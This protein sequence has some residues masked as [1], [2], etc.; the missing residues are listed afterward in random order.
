MKVFLDGNFNIKS[1]T[2]DVGE[3]IVRGSNS[4]DK[5]YVYVPTSVISDY[6]TISPLYA[7]KR[8]DGRELGKYATLTNHASDGDA[9]DN[10]YGWYGFFDKRDICV[11]GPLEITISF[12]LVKN[13]IASEKSVCKVTVDIKDGVM[14]GDDVLILDN[15]DWLSLKASIEALVTNLANKAD[16]TN[17][18]QTITGDKFYGSY[19]DIIEIV[20]NTVEALSAVI[21]NL[22]VQENITAGNINAT[23]INGTTIKQ[24]NNAVLDVR[25]I[26]DSFISESTT[27]ALSAKKGKEL[28]Y[29]VDTK[30]ARA[31]VVNNLT[32]TSINKPLSAKQGKILKDE[33][34]YIYTLLDSDDTSLDELQEIVTYIKNNKSLID[35]ITTSKVSVSDIV[36]NLNSNDT[37]K[38]LSAKQGHILK[39]LINNLQTAI[40]NTYT[41]S[42]TDDLLDDKADKSTTYTKDDVDDKLALK[43][44]ITIPTITIAGVNYTNLEQAIGALNEYA[45]T[46]EQVIGSISGTDTSI[47]TKLTQLETNLSNL[48]TAW[49]TFISGT[50]AD[51]II[52]T[53]SEIQDK[54]SDIDDEIEAIFKIKN[55]KSID[56]G[57]LTWSSSVFG[58][59]GYYTT[60]ALPDYDES[61]ITITSIPTIYTKKFPLVVSVTDLQAGDDNIE[62]ITL[63]KAGAIAV[64]TTNYSSASEFKAALDGVMLYYSTEIKEVEKTANKSLYHLGAFDTISGNTITRQTYYTT[65]TKADNWVLNSNGTIYYNTKSSGFIV[66]PSG[67]N[68]KGVAYCD[69]LELVKYDD[70]YSQSKTSGIA[71]SANGN[72]A[73]SVSDYANLTS[74]V[75]QCKLTTSYT[76][77]V[78]E[79]ES[80]L[81]LDSN[82]ANKIRQDVVERLNLLKVYDFVLQRNRANV[83]FSNNRLNISIGAN[84]SDAVYLPCNIL[85]NNTYT[86]SFN[87]NNLE[88]SD[89]YLSTTTDDSESGLFQRITNSVS[90]GS[91][92]FTASA[93]APYIRFW[94]TFT[95]SEQNGY[96]SNIMLTKSNHPYPYEPYHANKHITD[97]EATLLKQEEEKCSNLFGQSLYQGGWDYDNNRTKYSSAIR[98]CND[99]QTIVSPSTTYT[100]TNSG[101][102]QMSIQYRTSAGAIIS[103]SNWQNNNYTFTTPSNCSMIDIIFRNSDDSNLTPSQ[104]GNVMLNKGST[105]EPYQEWYGEIVHTKD[106]DPVLLWE[107]PNP[108][109]AYSGDVLTI[110]TLPNYKY[111]VIQFKTGD[112]EYTMKLPRGSSNNEFRSFLQ[113]AGYYNSNYTIGIRMVEQQPSTQTYLYIGSGANQTTV[114]SDNNMCVP[115]KIYGTNIL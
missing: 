83:S 18:Q 6:T 14:V 69:K 57:S 55:I 59:T 61:L 38:P 99:T 92:T 50:S 47:V 82:M 58:F 97:D 62:A 108:N 3:A 31:D 111:L 10:Y 7:V 115:T 101:N 65:L 34:D 23:T 67:D 72:I 56:L 36:D 30:V 114:T 96:I 75:V 91:Y 77:S 74:I 21:T 79:G 22:T 20:S 54:L 66:S 42:E 68:V 1:V 106:I 70:L 87:I 12:L 29:L 13:G 94:I 26:V 81:P 80:I 64:R 84:V 93:N 52:N 43:Q 35:G 41:K 110:P 107:N 16:R 45:K 86:L 113:S 112:Y 39:G 89:I 25:D 46:I 17:S 76:E 4:F 105:P 71:I 11:S 28:K 33:I 15:G 32:D 109:S 2:D 98:V 19:A 102:K 37:N 95:N 63:N 44:N 90:S 104:V 9:V 60:T 27:K 73:I 88:I 78:I 53:L 51:N 103:G 8:A 48:N 49:N 100:I 85:A 5:L 40:N 24:D